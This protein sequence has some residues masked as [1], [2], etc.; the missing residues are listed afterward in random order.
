MSSHI[1]LVA[2]LVLCA[3]ASLPPS[4][5]AA[6]QRAVPS[7]SP[8]KLELQYQPELQSDAETRSDAM[9]EPP[10]PSR[11]FWFFGERPVP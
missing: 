11:I 9:Q 8:G 6:G 5:P 4:D 1:A 2:P 10:K 3:C 7:T